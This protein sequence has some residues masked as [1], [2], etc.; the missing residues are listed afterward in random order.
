MAERVLVY[1]PTNI[2]FLPDALAHLIFSMMSSITSCALVT[3]APLFVL[4]P[5]ESYA[6]GLVNIFPLPVVERL[7]VAVVH[8]VV[9]SALCG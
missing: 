6:L 5:L 3:I 1:D 4:Q 7:A 9:G 2:L 8:K